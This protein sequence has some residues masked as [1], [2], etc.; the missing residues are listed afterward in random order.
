MDI[1]G[2]DPTGGIQQMKAKN[3]A[4]SHEIAVLKKGIDHQKDMAAQ[5][6]EA[7]PTVN[8]GAPPGQQVRM[9]A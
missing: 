1:S 4:Q 7:I 5:L 8:H 9:T 2:M 3:D 6:I